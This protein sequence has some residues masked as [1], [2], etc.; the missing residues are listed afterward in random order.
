[1]Y[2]EDLLDRRGDLGR[3]D[4]VFLDVL[5]G[6][7]ERLE[8]RR[9]GELGLGGLVGILGSEPLVVLGADPLALVLPRLFR[10][11]ASSPVLVIAL[12]LGLRGVP[13]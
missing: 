9:W 2:L 1:M 5:D 11:L 6:R 8:L 10:G 7:I 12:V 13:E 4:V 3:L